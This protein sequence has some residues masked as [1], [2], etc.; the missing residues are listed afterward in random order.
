MNDN[1]SVYIEFDWKWCYY[2][3]II[4][5]RLLYN[6]HL[7]IYFDYSILSSSRLVNIK[8][9]ARPTHRSLQ[10][11]VPPYWDYVISKLNF[12]N[13]FWADPVKITT[14]SSSFFGPPR[15]ISF[16]VS[17]FSF[18]LTPRFPALQAPEISDQISASP[19]NRI[20][21]TEQIYYFTIWYDVS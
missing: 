20:C 21:Y 19:R 12:P 11:K 18:P 4:L 5:Q 2:L 15:I 17:V 7:I 3:D 14:K 6:F 13:I 9:A 8:I 1:R 16:H 10:L